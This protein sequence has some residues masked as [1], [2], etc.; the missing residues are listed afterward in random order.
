MEKE[1]CKEMEGSE[2]NKCLLREKSEK[3]GV[4]E[5]RAAS[6]GGS[7]GGSKTETER[8]RQ[9]AREEEGDM[10]LELI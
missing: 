9:G 7:C 2:A 3:I 5:S 1:F 10:A 8:Q 6:S 4:E